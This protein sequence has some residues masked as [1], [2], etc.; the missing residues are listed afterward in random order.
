MSAEH[1]SATP[2]PVTAGSA[3]IPIP[4]K[5]A[6]GR[7]PLVDLFADLLLLA[8]S[9]QSP[10]D[11]GEPSQVRGR[12]LELLAVAERRGREAG[13]DPASVD[14]AR[15]A[16][17]AL[18]DELILGSS[19]AGRDTWRGNPLQRELFRINTAGE[20][21]FTRLEGLRG[22]R[23][24]S[25]AALEVYQACLSL[26]FEGRYK[27]AG[28]E[29]LGALR[30]DVASEVSSGRTSLDSLA[31]R[32]EP[33]DQVPEAAGEGIPVWMT[34]LGVLGGAILLVAIFALAAGASA[35]RVAATVRELYIRIAG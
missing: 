35:G 30:R 16:V 25:R 11:P 26:G 23:G 10:G 1:D 24:E 31:P 21:F 13:Y 33:R 34:L 15:F 4:P 7:T 14:H 17:V 28:A 18:L 20:E 19:W 29:K 5:T 2:L 8:Y 12:I 9:L 3:A 27:I 6:G 32:W 22:G